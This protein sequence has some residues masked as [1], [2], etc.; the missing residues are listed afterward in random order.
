MSQPDDPRRSALARALGRIPSGLFIVTAR[1]GWANA[2]LLASWL[3]QAGFAPAAVTVAIGRDREIVEIIERTGRLVVNQL[4][5]GQHRLMRHFARSM[6]SDDGAFPGIETL[7]PGEA[8]GGL[9][10]AD[11]MSYLDVEVTGFLEGDDH[12]IVL[13]RVIAGAVLHEDAK[14]MVHLRRNGF[15][16]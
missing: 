16:Y 1:D 13:G 14:P 9:V 4:S 7:E 11:A 3:Q 12:R 2:G 6:R 5:E 10:L 15:H 8:R